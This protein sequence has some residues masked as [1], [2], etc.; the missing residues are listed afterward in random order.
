MGLVLEHLVG[1]LFTHLALISSL[2]SLNSLFSLDTAV[3]SQFTY[4]MRDH[5]TCYNSVAKGA[6]P[7]FSNSRQLPNMIKCSFNSLF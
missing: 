7:N 5:M 4:H 2:A 3:E 6:C 1:M